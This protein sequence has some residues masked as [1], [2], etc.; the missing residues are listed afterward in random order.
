MHSQAI[1]SVEF[2]DGA[3][4]LVYEDAHG[5]YVLDDEDEA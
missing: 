3:T 4:R 1:A 2:A 5:Q